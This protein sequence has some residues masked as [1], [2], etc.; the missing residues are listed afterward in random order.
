MSHILVTGANGF[1]GSHLVRRLLELKKKNQWQE[2]IVC[3]VRN[4]SDISSLK[5]LDVKLVIADLR[6]PE[7]LVEPVKGATYI[8]H[9][10]GELFSIR[11][12]DFVDSITRGTE[13]LLKA[14]VQ[15]GGGKLKRF[16]YVSS[17]AAAGPVDDK[18]PITEERTPP[19][20]V[21]W[22][23]KTKW[24]AEKIAKKYMPQLPITIVRPSI[25]V[26][27]R[28]P[29]SHQLYT[30]VKMR[31][32]VLV[33]FKM[34]YTPIVYVK[35]VVE[36]MIAAAMHPD[37]KGETY[38][39]CNPENYSAQQINKAMAKAMSKRWGLTLPI[40]IFIFR[41]IATLRELFYLFFRVTP[42][43]TRDKV[44]EFAKPY[45]VCTPAK[46]KKDFG[47]EAKHSLLEGMKPTSDFFKE[48]ER[49]LKKMPS[50][51][52]GILWLKYFLLSLV[53]GGILE[54]LAA[55]GKLYVF[56]PW[57]VVLPLVPVFWGLIMG[58]IAMVMRT[59]RFL[60]QFLPGFLLLLGCEL[61]NHYYIHLWRYHNDSLCGIGNPVVR[62]VVVGII[63]GIYI[64]I[65]NALMRQFYK[66]K[67]RV[68]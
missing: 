53:L 16:V 51:P 56:Q 7:T 15:H 46:A 29:A 48:E 37:T 43:P 68:G 32:H 57:W 1:I 4:T 58:F 14:V 34:S 9:L 44:R 27:E 33:G 67:L 11:G 3:M 21:S 54:A 31:I 61:L 60:V 24:E 40:P 30:M 64:L 35:D 10:A 63:G 2:E 19:P 22:Y 55:F 65:I 18:T 38:F 6:E 12:K 50:E 25:V 42:I 59:C 41:I 20:P 52:R 45:W 17:Q 62:A 39:L 28:D 47:W 66:Y 49:R 5:G 36:G 13:N 26:G 23:S 8:Y